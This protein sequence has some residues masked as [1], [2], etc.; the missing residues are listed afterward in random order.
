MNRHD[1]TIASSRHVRDVSD[2]VL[3][4]GQ[5]LPQ[6]RDRHSETALTN[7]GGRPCP[8]DQFTLSNDLTSGI[9]KRD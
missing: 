1:Q 5:Y 2:P 4:V 3:T 8:G 6:I 7:H 9:C